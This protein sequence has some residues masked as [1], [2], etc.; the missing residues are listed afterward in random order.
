MTISPP[1]PRTLAKYGLAADDW[2]AIIEQQGGVCPICKEVPKRWVT[3]HLHVK[4][5]KQM[6]AEKK[7]LYVRGVTCW[8]CNHWYL[9]RGITIERAENVVGYLKG[10]QGKL[11]E[12]AECGKD[13]DNPHSTSMC[14][15]CQIILLLNLLDDCEKYGRINPPR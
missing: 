7:K 14:Y 11:H 3:D 13:T 1:S 9:G 8:R 2:L 5:Y 6:P 4:G 15:D 12:C 10:F